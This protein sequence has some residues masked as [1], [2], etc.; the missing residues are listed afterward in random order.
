MTRCWAPSGSHRILEELENAQLFTFTDDGGMYFRYHEVL[1]THLELALVEEYGPPEAREWYLKSAG[2]LESVGEARS[3]ARAYAKA[4]DW[5]S[6]SRLVK[7]TGGPR[8]DATVLDDAR[9]A[10]GER[11]AHRPVAG[12]GQRSPIGS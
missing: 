1:Q 7:D 8:I 4:G 11:V 10:A 3:A 2:V 5:V 9:L 6:V 12:P